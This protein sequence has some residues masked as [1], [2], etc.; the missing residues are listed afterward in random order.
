MNQF[1]KEFVFASQNRG[2]FKEMQALFASIDTTVRFL[3]D[4]TTE[5]VEE[6]GLSFYENAILKARFASKLTQLPALGDDSGL[7]INALNLQP[8]IYSARYAGM[9]KDFNKNIQKVLLNMQDIKDRGA[10]FVCVLAF[11]N[12]ANDPLPKLYGGFWHGQIT[13][14]PKGT[15]GFGYDPIFFDSEH[16]CTAAE[17]GQLIKNR[18][19]HRSKA[20][21][22]LLK[23]YTF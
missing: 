15:H 18:L 11:C 1:P 22:K 17:M 6:T 16:Q 3:G 10:F 21:E 20:L 14:E 23:D 2:K 19:S 8:G 13:L 7:C 9:E 5:D 4:I 12:H